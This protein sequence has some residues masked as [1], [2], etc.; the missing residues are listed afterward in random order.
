M[1]A[2]PCGGWI[3]KKHGVQKSVRNIWRKVTKNLPNIN[4]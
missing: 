4:Q 1:G 2:L 3:F